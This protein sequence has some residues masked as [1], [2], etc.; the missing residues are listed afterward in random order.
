MNSSA[1]GAFEKRLLPLF[2]TIFMFSLGV[3]IAAPIIPLLA[4]SLGASYTEVGLVGTSY[5]I[6]FIMFAALSGKLSD[7]LG[8]RVLILVS[9][10]LNA[11]AA[12]LYLVAR[13]VNEIILI[14]TLEGLAWAAFWPSVEALTTEIASASASGRAMGLSS[15]SYGTGFAFGS[16]LGGSIAATTGYRN[17]FYFYLLPSM[18]AAL[19]ISIWFKDV[20]IVNISEGD[21]RVTPQ[22]NELKVSLWRSRPFLLSNVIAASYT[23]VLGTL[24]TLF[25]VYAKGLGV[26]VFWIGV[27][28]TLFWI[29]RIVSSMSAGRISDRVGRRSILIPA[30]IGCAIASFLAAIS[31]GIELLSISMVIM[32]ISIGAVFPVAVALIS[33][34]VHTR[35]RGVAMGIFETSCGIG[36]MTAATAGGIV[37]DQ[38]NPRYP[39]VLCALISIASVIALWVALRHVEVHSK[40]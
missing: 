2:I 1:R 36:L 25:S 20:R 34:N 19:T 17:T 7:R 23:F 33:D 26:E 38:F 21:Q 4:Q 9:A 3:G 27:L 32:G 30:L 15:A 11:L 5:S 35:Q 40:K 39:Y 28:F 6:I 10:V 29:G 24:L 14:R 13:N 31:V 37:A 8:R 18:I 16:L 12:A 22:S